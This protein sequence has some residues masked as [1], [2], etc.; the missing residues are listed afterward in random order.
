MCKGLAARRQIGILAL[1]GGGETQQRPGRD[2][3][4]AAPPTTHPT[5]GEAGPAD[6]RPAWGW[7][8]SSGHRRTHR[9]RPLEGQ[10]GPRQRRGQHL[11]LLA[12]PPLFSAEG[13]AAA[14]CHRH[15]VTA[16]R[17]QPRPAR[18]GGTGRG[19]RRGEGSRRGKRGGRRGQELGMGA[20]AKEQE[21]GTRERRAVG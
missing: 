15:Q 8:S 18:R 6:G 5:L 10:S 1:L 13:A 3:Q 4:G 12:G 16:T 21:W 14:N 17:R 9:P 20:K 11:S 7:R 19:Q 2:P